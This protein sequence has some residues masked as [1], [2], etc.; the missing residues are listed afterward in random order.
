MHK[1]IKFVM[2]VSLLAIAIPH[3]IRAQGILDADEAAVLRKKVSGGGGSFPSGALFD[4]RYN[5]D[6]TDASGNGNN[7]SVIGGTAHYSTNE[8]NVATKS[9]AFNGSSDVNGLTDGTIAAFTT[10]DFTVSAWVFYDA[11]DFT[12]SPII[13][14]K[15]VNTSSGYYGQI[16][17]ADAGSDLAGYFIYSFNQSGAIQTVRTADR[18]VLLNTWYNVVLTKIGTTA[19]L[20]TNGVFAASAT[21]V[22]PTANTTLKFQ[23]GKYSGGGFFWTGNIA[24]LTVWARGLTTTEIGNIYSGGSL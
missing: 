22:N 13:F 4:W 23:A 20:Y 19:T 10:S 15:G 17:R 5:G 3:G 12:A 24:Q 18:S 2:F 11:A 14:S 21:V 7:S 16:H 9:A 6:L 8:L 1:F